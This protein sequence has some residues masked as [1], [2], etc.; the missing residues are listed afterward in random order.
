MKKTIL[1]MA[2]L[3]LMV[4][5][6]M[7]QEKDQKGQINKLTSEALDKQG[8]DLDAQITGIGKK[9]ADIIKNYELLKAPV[10]FI[11][12]QTTL[13]Q[14]ADFIEMEKHSFVKDETYARDITGI[15][16]K[17]IKIFTNGQTVSKIESEIYERDYYSGASN[18]VKISDPSPTAEGSDDVVFSHIVNG[19]VF[20]DA[21]KM[22]DMKNTTAFPIRNDLKREFLVP[23]MS[24]F[25]NSL[26][27]IA[28]A[29]YKGLKDAESGMADFL[30]RSKKY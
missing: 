28:E 8:R 2:C 22:G 19:K 27:F 13:V 24:Y 21:K 9:I 12:Y 20:L 23:H 4:A 10:R 25:M 26:L 11:P 14:G 17:K 16:I 15:Q 29:Y 7:A 3:V 5:V 6:S 1:V 30:K 18:I